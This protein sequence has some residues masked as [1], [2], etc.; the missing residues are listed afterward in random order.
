MER[1]HHLSAPSP[2]GPPPALKSRSLQDLRAQVVA[3]QANSLMISR[4]GH[5]LSSPL[6]G[7]DAAAKVAI[8]LMSG[9]V[10][11]PDEEKLKESWLQQKRMKEE[12]DQRKAEAL[13]C[14]TKGMG[15]TRG[16]PPP[17]SVNVRILSFHTATGAPKLSDFMLKMSS[18]DPSA[19]GSLM[20]ALK[21]IINEYDHDCPD[22]DVVSM[23][24]A[25][26]LECAPRA[27][28]ATLV[29]DSGRPE[30]NLKRFDQC[31]GT[32]GYL[33]FLCNT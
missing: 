31:V 13:T 15:G 27:S 12:E 20:E 28:A 14:R 17:K 7:D 21:Q 2:H 32:S 16:T 5:E 4:K 22:L 10:L 6:A 8:K 24:S 1:R 3:V 19:P 30:A 23:G 33:Y 25:M 9:E 11:T 26:L 29:F 18:T